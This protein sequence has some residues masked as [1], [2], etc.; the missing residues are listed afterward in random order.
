MNKYYKLGF[1]LIVLIFG[2]LIISPMIKDFNK[3]TEVIFFGAGDADSILIKNKSGNV[4]IDTGLKE[5]REALG[6]KLRLLGVRTIDY[7]ILTHPDKDHIGGASYVIENFNVKN[8]IQS[9]YEKGTKG[10]RRIKKSLNNSTTKNIILT[11]DYDFKIGHLEFL[12]YSPKKETYEKSNDYSL[13]AHV[14]DRNLNY[15]FT[16]DAEKT[17]L[18]ELLEVNYPK[19]D[20]YKVPHHGRWN[21]NSENMIKKVSPEIAVITSDTGDKGVVNALENEGSTIYYAFDED[22]HFYSDGVK[23]EKR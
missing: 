20:L 23:L 5:D 16:G 8:L 6:D 13:V 22:I 21:G 12:I 15:L 7:M 9:K 4:L 3:G 19:M 10:E 2:F 11:E 1:L 18:K 17:L 14:K